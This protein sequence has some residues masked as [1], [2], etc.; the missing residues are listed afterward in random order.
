MNRVYVY[1]ALTCIVFKV[2][3]FILRNLCF[4]LRQILSYISKH[5][6][7]IVFLGLK[8]KLR[9]KRKFVSFLFVQTEIERQFLKFK[10]ITLSIIGLLFIYILHAYYFEE[11]EEKFAFFNM[12]FNPDHASMFFY[13]NL[14]RSTCLVFYL[15]INIVHT[16]FCTFL[17]SRTL[18]STAF[19]LTPYLCS[20][21]SSDFQAAAVMGKAGNFSGALPLQIT[22]SCLKVHF[23]FHPANLANS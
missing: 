2:Y 12:F 15:S 16:Y 21:L 7:K 9:R 22:A 17:I 19:V 11:E 14:D 18:S 10:I 3:Y 23:I 4:V 8:S 1:K 13:G 20:H 6:T 5:Q